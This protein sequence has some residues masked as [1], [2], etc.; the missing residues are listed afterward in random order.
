MK[1]Q[2]YHTSITVDATAQ[3]VF[4]SINSISQWWTENWE[5]SSQKLNDIF[6]VHFGQTFITLKITESIP[7]KKIVWYVTDCNKHWLKNKK[8]WKGTQVTWEISTKDKATQVDFTHLGLVPD[9]EC[10][11]VCENAWT[12]YLHNS[13]KNLVTSGKGQPNKKEN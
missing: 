9:L 12:G 7:G 3:E 13:L 2:D 11:D 8:E 10:Y 5:G 1:E 6:T 4:E